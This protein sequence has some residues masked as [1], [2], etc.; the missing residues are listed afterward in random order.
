MK[1]CELKVTTHFYLSIWLLV[2]VF[3]KG[4]SYVRVNSA[5]TLYVRSELD[6]LMCRLFKSRLLS[7]HG[8][9]LSPL[10]HALALQL[11]LPGI[12]YLVTSGQGH[13]RKKKYCTK[14]GNTNG[15]SIHQACFSV[16][17]IPQITGSAE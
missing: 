6:R 4:P 16:S 17:M 11:I 7:L 12:P 15:S 2:A 9:H 5:M 14:L 1:N 10:T 13:I 8:H 3:V